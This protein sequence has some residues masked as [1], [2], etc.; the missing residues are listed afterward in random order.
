M[1]INADEKF[2]EIATPYDAKIT[3]L[4]TKLNG[5][6]VPYGTAQA[7]QAAVENQAA[8]DS[9]A[10]S[11]GGTILNATRAATK[12]FGQLQ[13]FALGF[14]RCDYRKE[15]RLERPEDEQ[16]PRKCANS[17]LPVVRNTSMPS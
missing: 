16:L 6:Y 15:G 9:N 1:S 11:S 7:R 3:E 5:T 2:V 4:S 8:Q 12:N 13:K 10:I 17:M 14:V